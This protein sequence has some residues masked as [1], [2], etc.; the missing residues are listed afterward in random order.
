[1]CLC[2]RLIGAVPSRSLEEACPP[3]CGAAA[4]VGE[5]PRPWL[6]L[7][8]SIFFGSAFVEACGTCGSFVS[9]GRRGS[10]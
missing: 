1:M 8:L 5:E 3:G 2:C 10:P 6:G 9:P 7:R 4:G